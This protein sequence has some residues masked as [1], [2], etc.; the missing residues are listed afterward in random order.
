MWSYMYMSQDKKCRLTCGDGASR[1][2]CMGSLCSGMATQRTTV[3]AAASAN[4]R[5]GR[6]IRQLEVYGHELCVEK[7]RPGGLAV[8]FQGVVE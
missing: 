2:I 4:V 1:N 6:S 8:H 7:K 5:T 3:V